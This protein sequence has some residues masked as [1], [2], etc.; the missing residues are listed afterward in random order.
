MSPISPNQ[1]EQFFVTLQE[2]V[3]KY[4]LVGEGKLSV[5]CER[6]FSKGEACFRLFLHGSPHSPFCFTGTQLGHYVA[7]HSETAS[8]E[9][10]SI[11]RCVEDRLLEILE[12]V[13]YGSII[14]RL[15]TTRK[16]G[17][18]VTIQQCFSHRYLFP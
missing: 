10:H 8:G 3:E 18:T 2:A 15:E 4:C 12:K 13:G 17:L 1:V 9:T 16:K 7:Q 11:F 5:D 6:R 14:F